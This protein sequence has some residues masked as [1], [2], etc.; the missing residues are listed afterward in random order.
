MLRP[1]GVLSSA[2]LGAVVS[3][4]GGELGVRFGHKGLQLFLK[5]LV[6][7]L[8]RGGLHRSRTLLLRAVLRIVATFPTGR[9]LTAGT[10]SVLPGR[11]GL[12]PLDG[13]ID[14]AVFVADDNDLHILSLSQ[15]GTDVADIGIGDLRDMYHTG[16]ILRQGDECTK[17]G[18][19]FDFAFQNGSNG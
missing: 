16:L 4:H 15:M 10:G 8:G 19:G 2:A 14:L 11:L 6:S 13:Q 17:I 12:Q 9:G 18:N 3:A 5:E 7:S 1:W